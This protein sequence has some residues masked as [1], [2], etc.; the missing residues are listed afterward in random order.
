MVIQLLNEGVGKLTPSPSIPVYVLVGGASQRFGADKA[1]TVVDGEPWALHVGRRLATEGGEIVLVGRTP[2]GAFDGLRRVDDLE[3]LSGPLAGILAALRDRLDKYGVG[4]LA[5]AS[6]DL[7]RPERVWLEPLVAE[8]AGSG[9][10]DIAAYRAADRWQPFPSVAHTR[11][12]PALSEQAAA[13]TRSLQAA[14]DGAN[15][16]AIDWTLGNEGP[17]QANSVAELQ[18]KL[19]CEPGDVSPRS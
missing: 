1:T 19:T 18:A 10:L 16:T 11:W 6:C 12:L 13:G 17:P 5:F 15:A 14:L 9:A 2:G 3:G 7:V 4:L 8:F